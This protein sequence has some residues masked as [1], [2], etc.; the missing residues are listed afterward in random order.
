MGKL[1]QRP[2][3][4]EEGQS[5]EEGRGHSSVAP[6]PWQGLLAFP[7]ATVLFWVHRGLEGPQQG[8][9]KANAFPKCCP[10]A[11]RNFKRLWVGVLGI[12]CLTKHKT[13]FSSCSYRACAGSWAWNVGGSTSCRSACV[14]QMGG[15]QWETEWWRSHSS[16][17]TGHFAFLYLNFLI[18]EM[19][20]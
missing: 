9:G 3:G 4:N 18:F 2:L 6:G 19:G 5:K 10:Q 14:G 20:E 17:V 7:G 13:D 8:N 11:Q 1:S 15:H 16:T 12:I